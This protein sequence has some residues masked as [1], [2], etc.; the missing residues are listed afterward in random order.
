MLIAR[1]K[2]VASRTI[3]TYPYLSLHEHDLVDDEADAKI[4]T[5]VTLSLL[6]WC[7]TT[8]VTADR[9]WV[10]VEQHRHGVDATTLEPAGG[11]IDP[12]ELP[13]VAAVRELREE[14]GFEGGALEPL[15]WVHPNPAL[16]AN[17]AHLFLV[18]GVVRTREPESSPEER[19]AVRLLDERE[20]EQGIVDG[21][22]SH[23]LGV[24]AL[25]RALQRLRA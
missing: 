15:G 1:P 2:R 11:I 17:R 23:A 4:R 9:R 6:D 8:A 3:A 13:E 24:L 5:A 21:R 18:R 16:S 20:V 10:L 7:V 22:V 19:T 25:T 14:T 12:G